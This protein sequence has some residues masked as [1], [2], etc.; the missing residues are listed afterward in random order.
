MKIRKP[1]A[2]VFFASYVPVT[3]FDVSVEVVIG[4]KRHDPL[5]ENTLKENLN[6]VSKLKQK[7]FH[8]ILQK[9]CVLYPP[10]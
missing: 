4:R 7:C 2:E 3:A 6:A 10:E 5:Y 1:K 8:L 9:L